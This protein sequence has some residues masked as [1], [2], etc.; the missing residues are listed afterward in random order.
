MALK[1][2]DLKA[3]LTLN[4]KQY[5]LALKDSDEGAKKF[6]KSTG[7]TF[8]AWSAAIK[9]VM[10][11]VSAAFAFTVIAATKFEKQLSNV[12]TMTTRVAF[13][14]NKFKEGIVLAARAFGQST[15]TLT[16][17]LYDILSASIPANKAMGLLNVSA[18]AASAGMTETGVAADALTTL[19]N[20]FGASADD[21]G[22]FS[23]LLF[24]I[25]KNGKC[26]TGNTRVLLADGRYERIDSLSGENWIVSWDYRNFTPCVGRFVDMGTKR[27]VAI[28]TA[29]GREIVTTPEHPYLTA[30]G[31][32]KVSELNEGDRIAVPASL[33]F[34]GTEEPVDGLAELFEGVN[35][36][37]KGG[38]GNKEALVYNL[39]IDDGHGLLGGRRFHKVVGMKNDDLYP[40]HVWIIFQKL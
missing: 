19:I 27:T 38:W 7:K 13:Q 32:K 3:T 29:S 9:A 34:F 36:L 39:A 2:G 37:V 1:V 17:G 35:V 33:P 6:S 31:W 22:F 20:S 40:W 14:N 21:A 18:V 12:L 15:K 8:T 28:H 25:V 11:A 4:N 24:T 10:V 5:E 30:Q 16:D 23:D 26:V